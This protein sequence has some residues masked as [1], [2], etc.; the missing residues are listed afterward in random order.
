MESP[1]ETTDTVTLTSAAPAASSDFSREARIASIIAAVQNGTYRVDSK[2][3]ANAI[4]SRML[5]P[6]ADVAQDGGS[7][8]DTS[9]GA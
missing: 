9:T 7:E 1:D 8:Q 4:I 2:A 6:A 3:V 5:E